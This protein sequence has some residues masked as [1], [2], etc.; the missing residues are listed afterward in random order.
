MAAEA[1]GPVIT[2]AR[3]GDRADVR[4]HSLEIGDRGV[5]S[6]IARTP[7]GLLPLNVQLRGGFNVENVLAAVTV[8]ELLEVPLEAVRTG[9]AAVPGVPGRF[10][11][12]DAGQDFAVLVDYAHTPDGLQNVLESAREITSGRLICVF[13]CGGDRDRGKRPLMGRIARELADIP[14][15]TSDNPRSEDPAAI[16]AEIMDGNPMTSETDRRAAIALA[17]GS[18]AAWGRCGDRRQGARAG[19]AVPRDGAAVRR[20]HRGDRAAVR[21]GHM[22]SLTAHEVAAACGVETRLHGTVTGLSVDSRAVQPGDLFVAL[23]GEHTDGAKFVAAAHAA[24]ATLALTTAV[25]DPLRDIA[26]P[27]PLI[28]LGQVA[29]R[30]QATIERNRDRHHRLDRQDVHQGHPGSA[31]DSAGETPSPVPPTSTPRSVYL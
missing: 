17:V 12:V 13:G 14:I 28:A 25:T 10:E 7:R 3:S 11:S 15:V 16:I 4:P 26:V 19:P 18:G 23:P 24:G 8:A 6:L 1:G 30:G 20:S 27:D 2:Y 29:A 21:G 9:I 22:I 5:I 31:A